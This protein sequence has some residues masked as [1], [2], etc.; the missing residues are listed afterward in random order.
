MI[1]RLGFIIVTLFFLPISAFASII[2]IEYKGHISS[3]NGEN[4]GYSVGDLVGGSVVI[5]LSKI[6]GIDY[7]SSN[8][9]GVN[10][11]ASKGLLTSSNYI[12]AD[13]GDFYD[14][15]SLYDGNPGYFGSDSLTLAEVLSAQGTI[16]NSFHL[17]ISSN[18]DWITN[19]LG[20]NYNLE[21]SDSD[22]LKNSWGAFSRWDMAMGNYH[23]I[24]D[25]RIELDFVKVHSVSA[26]EP[27]SLVLSFLGLFGLAFRRKMSHI[28]H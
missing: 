21:L 5:D 22:A 9:L 10:A 14:L 26:P 16:T 1:A 24:G 15:L 11:L 25:A 13:T 18:Q 20:K 4:M 23:S 2:N 27:S 8:A 17:G 6:D 3:A 7:S 28:L 19:L 12:G